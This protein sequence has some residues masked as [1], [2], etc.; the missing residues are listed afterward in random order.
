MGKNI[1]KFTEPVKSFADLLQEDDDLN[2]AD[3]ELKFDA[4]GN[5]IITAEEIE[6]IESDTDGQE[7]EEQEED[8][9][10]SVETQ[11]EKAK[12]SAPE[13]KQQ[14][15]P[16]KEQLKIINMK[17]DL[18]R[19]QQEKRELEER[20]SKIDSEKRKSEIV[21]KYVMDGV[22][23][24]VAE[25]YAAQEIRND[26]IEEKLEIIDFRESNYDLLQK[27]PQ[28]RQDVKTIIRN[29]K[30]TGM[31]AEQ[32]CKGMYADAET[33]SYQQRIRQQMTDKTDDSTG[34]TSTEAAARASIPKQSVGSSTPDRRFI[35]ILENKINGGKTFS[36]DDLKIIAKHL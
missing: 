19:V 18:Q 8:T 12:D 11:P 26:M 13:K 5:V 33:P 28:A 4:E 24:E 17:K 6:S 21:K 20:I 27:Y 31:T 32:I 10:E 7:P 25:K 3:D 23:E 36:E 16:S 2:V 1:E 15:T 30:L 29:A 14:N 35:K 34:Q 9:E 22:D